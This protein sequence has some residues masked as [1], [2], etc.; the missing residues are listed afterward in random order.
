MIFSDSSFV[1]TISL[2][3]E[4]ATTT[5][6]GL[7]YSGNSVTI[8]DSFSNGEMILHGNSNRA[9]G[10]GWSLV[11]TQINRTYSAITFD[12]TNCESNID[13]YIG[14]IAGSMSGESNIHN[15]MY[16]G[17]LKIPEVVST[18]EFGGIL[19]DWIKKTKNVHIEN[20]YSSFAIN[21]VRSIDDSNI[22][23]ICNSGSVVVKS[24]Y[25]D[26]LLSGIRLRFHTTQFVSHKK[27][28]G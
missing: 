11:D 24:S 5:G 3:Q 20:S 16:I 4:G 21:D 6:G 27:W 18:I 15:S 9:G 22:D 28:L 10:I 7:I 14:G 13:V 19:K 1:G 23:G 25:T 17:R 26:T 8:T 12:S 2:V